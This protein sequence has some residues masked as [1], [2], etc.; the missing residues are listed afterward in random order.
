MLVDMHSTP[1]TCF[2]KAITATLFLGLFCQAQAQTTLITDV[3]GY[4]LNTERE[5]V[6]FTALQFTGNTIDRLYTTEDTLPDS[7]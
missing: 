2:A 6:R 1:T 5:L 4:T 3:N 7:A